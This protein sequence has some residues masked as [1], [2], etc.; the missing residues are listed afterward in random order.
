MNRVNHHISDSMSINRGN[1]AFSDKPDRRMQLQH[2]NGD[3]WNQHLSILSL[4]FE[5]GLHIN[6]VGGF[7]CLVYISERTMDLT[8]IFQ[9]VEST[10]DAVC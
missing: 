8:H 4:V 1:A 7:N 10:S 5:R 2:F 6:L 3:E 9:L